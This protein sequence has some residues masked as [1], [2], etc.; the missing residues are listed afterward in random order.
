[1]MR[2]HEGTLLRGEYD[3]STIARD[4]VD[5]AVDRKASDV[6]LLDIGRA[7]TLADYFVIA[8][9]TSD[10]Q[11]NAVANAVQERMKEL[12]V[13]ILAREGLPADG[14]ILL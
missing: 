8:T 14:W 7:T 12:G 2:Q 6:T 5:V 1:M 4:I 11:M 9:G 13:P 10:R 3:A